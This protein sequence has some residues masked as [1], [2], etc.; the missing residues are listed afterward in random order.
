MKAS[1]LYHPKSETSRVVEEFIHEFERTRNKS[2]NP[3][4]LETKEGAELAKLYGIVSY[5][6]VIVTRDNGE[7]LKHWEGELLPSMDEVAG[8]LAQ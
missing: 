2:I 5:P 4:S 6:A 8:Y 3:V 7:Y 1:I